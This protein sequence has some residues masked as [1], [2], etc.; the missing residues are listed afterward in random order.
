VKQRIVSGPSKHRTQAIGTVLQKLLD[1]YRLRDRVNEQKV[2]LNFE[3]IMGEQFCRR[4]TAVKIEHGVLFIETV[5]SV[6]R[7]ELFYQKQLIKDRINNFFNE[8][9]VKEI[10]FR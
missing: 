10:I 8:P 1:T 6:W 5:N 2:I 7:H 9:L 3:S 4:A